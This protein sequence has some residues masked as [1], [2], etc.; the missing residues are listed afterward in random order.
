MGWTSQT[1]PNY[2]HVSLGQDNQMIE[3]MVGRIVS[4]PW[5]VE[6]VHVMPGRIENLSGQ[7]FVN[8]HEYYI[9][10][11]NQVNGTKLIMLVLVKEEDNEV[12]WKEITESMGPCYYNCPVSWFNEVPDPGSY[13]TSWRQK[14]LDRQLGGSTLW[15]K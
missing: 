5:A 15:T 12:Y 9:K 11:T 4:Y 1:I 10:M 8:D 6:A 2:D 7:K 14:C 3:E 13:A